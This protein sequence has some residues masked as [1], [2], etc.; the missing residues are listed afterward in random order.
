MGNA[1]GKLR[2]ECFQREFGL[3]TY[4]ENASSTP[5]S[6]ATMLGDPTI[7]ASYDTTQASPNSVASYS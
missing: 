3:D 6:S 2:E 1:A 5:S 4:E 7:V